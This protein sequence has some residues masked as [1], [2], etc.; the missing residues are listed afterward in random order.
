MAGLEKITQQVIEK[1]KKS[2]NDKVEEE[3]KH[4]EEEIQ[5]AKQS[6]EEKHQRQSERID[7]DVAN[8]YD[9]ELNSISINERNEKLKIKQ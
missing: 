3:R 4:A 1:E 2:L 5:A 6:A 9:I 8:Q 7:Q